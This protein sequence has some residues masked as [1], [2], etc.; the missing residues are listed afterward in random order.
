[1]QQ[2]AAMKNNPNRRRFS[3]I[4]FSSILTIFITICFVTFAALSILTAHSDYKL[5]QKVADKTTAYYEADAQ[6]KLLLADLDSNLVLLYKMSQSEDDYFSQ[7]AADA[8]SLPQI[9]AQKADGTLR[10]FEVT[11]DE[12]NGTKIACQITISDV[13]YLDI[14]LQVLYPVEENDVFYRVLSWRT[15]TMEQ[16]STEESTLHLFT[17]DSN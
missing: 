17:G 5:T 15:R 11:S 1:M 8:W 10:S 6:A 13:Q 7:V 3:N 14:T 2:E 16:E 4:G 12:E 9:E